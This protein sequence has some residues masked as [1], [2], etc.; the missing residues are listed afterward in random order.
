MEARYYGKLGETVKENYCRKSSHCKKGSDADRP[1]AV[2]GN[3]I[4]NNH[5]TGHQASAQSGDG[6]HDIEH[7]NEETPL[8]VTQY[9]YDT[10]GRLQR[11]TYPDGEVLTYGYDAG[12]LVNSAVGVKGR[13]S[14][15]YLTRL[16]YDKFDQRVYLK[17]GNGV[18][19]SYTYRP[20]NRRLDA[21]QAQLP[22]ITH[23]RFQNLAYRYD[24]VGNILG[25]ANKVE[26][27]GQVLQQCTPCTRLSQ[28]HALSELN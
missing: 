6:S 9:K 13:H 3:T 27:R 4:V 21:L 28:C 22:N 24:N 12:G 10:F 5:E 8:Y 17:L 14:Y 15:A 2:P 20:D 1:G 25:I 23:Y 16:D 18:E 11:L 19:T 26:A 7:D